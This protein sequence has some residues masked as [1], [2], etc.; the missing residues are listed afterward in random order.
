MCEHGVDMATLDLEHSSCEFTLPSLSK[1]TAYKHAPMAL[2][3]ASPK[4]NKSK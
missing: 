4:S 1:L 2:C 3:E